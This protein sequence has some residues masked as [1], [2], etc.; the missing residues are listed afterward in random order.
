MLHLIKVFVL[1]FH[2]YTTSFLPYQWS[3]LCFSISSCYFRSWEQTF[4]V[5]EPPDDLIPNKVF[6]LLINIIS[7]LTPLFW[8]GFGY[9]C[10]QQF[11]VPLFK[12]IT[13]FSFYKMPMC[14]RQVLSDTGYLMLLRDIRILSLLNI[15]IFPKK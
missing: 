5:S 13:L 4:I 10:I 2:Y 14:R 7:W 15:L 1:Y 12:P 3:F 11:Y 9:V 6:S 8:G